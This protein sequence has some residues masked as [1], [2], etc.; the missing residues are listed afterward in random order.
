MF[1]SKSIAQ[2]NFPIRIIVD[3]EKGQIR[4]AKMLIDS[5]FQFRSR[6]TSGA[7]YETATVQSH[8]YYTMTEHVYLVV[9]DDVAREALREVLRSI[10]I[11]P[12]IVGRDLAEIRAKNNPG[13]NGKN[14]VVLDVGM[15]GGWDFALYEELRALRP[16]MRILVTTSYDQQDVERFYPQRK[17]F[18][19]LYKPYGA[20]TFISVVRS[21]L[22]H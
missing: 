6:A 8:L 17:P 9:R 21:M 15:P 10:G 20:Q 18:T 11:E 5:K 14:L 1:Y 3:K 12:V 2:I 19:V 16:G 7:G 4:T 13:K 22:N